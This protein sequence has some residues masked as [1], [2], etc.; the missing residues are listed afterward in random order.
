VY[1]YNIKILNNF[2]LIINELILI[3]NPDGV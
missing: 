1:I 2:L 3:N